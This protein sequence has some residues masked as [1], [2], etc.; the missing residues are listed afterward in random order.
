GPP[1]PKG[2]QGRD[3]NPGIPG[4]QGLPGP[5]G[6]SG[7][8]GKNGLPG[9]PGPAGPPGPPGESF[10]YD[11][12]ALQALLGSRQVKGPDPILGDEPLQLFSS[13]TPPEEKKRIVFK[14]YDKMVNEY[15]KFR[16]PTGKPDA[17]A[18]TCRDLSEMQPELPNGIYWIDPNQGTSKDAIEVY[19][20]ME[21]KA[22]CLYPISNE[23]PKKSYYKGRS[24]YTWFSEMNDGFT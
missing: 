2:P 6:P 18:R 13:D 22:T 10:G 15:K 19:C 12:A 8:S 1:G 11:A 14:F 16:R 23:I 21:N 4:P 20:D 7:E 5:R 9:P 17:P 24:V 3:G